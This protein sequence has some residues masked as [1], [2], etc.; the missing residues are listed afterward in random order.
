MPVGHKEAIIGFAPKVSDPIEQYPV[1]IQLQY[2]LVN[3][4][5]YG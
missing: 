3:G 1:S 4:A 5:V 2:Q